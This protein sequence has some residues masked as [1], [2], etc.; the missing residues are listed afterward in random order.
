MVQLSFCVLSYLPLLQIKECKCIVTMCD[1]IM[2][3]KIIH[4]IKMLTSK[5]FTTSGANTKLYLQAHKEP[6]AYNT[7]DIFR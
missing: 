4:T 2:Y 5:H 3:V 1:V 6:N 7:I